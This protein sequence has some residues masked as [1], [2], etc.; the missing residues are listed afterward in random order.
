MLAFKVFAANTLLT[1][2]HPPK[3]LIGFYSIL[4]KSVQKLKDRQGPVPAGEELARTPH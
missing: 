1:T 4:E 3:N 2:F